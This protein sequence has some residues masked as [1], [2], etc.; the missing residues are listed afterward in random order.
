M[1]FLKTLEKRYSMRKSQQSPHQM[2]DVPYVIHSENP[3]NI[4]LYIGVGAAA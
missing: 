1:K 3:H 4:E 2:Y